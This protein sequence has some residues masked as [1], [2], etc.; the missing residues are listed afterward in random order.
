MVLNKVVGLHAAQAVEEDAPAVGFAVPA[1]QSTHV[2][3][4]V[5]PTVGENLPGAHS[6]QVAAPVAAAYLPAAQNVHWKKALR[7]CKLF[8]DLPAGQSMHDVWPLALWYLPATQRVHEV[9]AGDA[10]YV[11][12]AQSRQVVTEV[13]PPTLLYLPAVH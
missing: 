8:V 10:E 12:A 1:G 7:P 5:A 3:E 4:E 6:V 2:K 13:A 9:E 11:P